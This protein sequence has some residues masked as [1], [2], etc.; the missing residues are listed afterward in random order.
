MK[1]IEIKILEIN[2]EEVIKKLIA[3]GAKKIASE[4]QKSYFFDFPDCR[5]KNDK[6]SLRLRSFGDRNF[7]TFKKAVSSDGAKIEDE[8]E[9][10][11]SSISETENLFLSLGLERKDSIGCI[12]TKYKIANVLFE[13]DEYPKVPCFMEIEAPSK[14]IIYNWVDKLNIDM[15]KIKAW[16][17]RELFAHYGI[18]VYH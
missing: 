2:K 13:I 6:S 4:K 10:D 7:V 12:R 9:I 11:V 8:T 1:E 5:I 14:E 18:K 3:L 17:G 15:S 16:S